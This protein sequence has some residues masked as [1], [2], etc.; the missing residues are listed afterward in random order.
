MSPL[1]SESEDG[2]QDLAGPAVKLY[3]E[4]EGIGA[5][6][7]SF[8]LD[9]RVTVELQKRLRGHVDGAVGVSVAYENR[10]G[11]GSIR[12][13]VEPQKIAAARGAQWSVAALTRLPGRCLTVTG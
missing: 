2:D 5:M 12:I 1:A 13:Q 10:T 11:R 8:F 3:V 4:F 9:D 7:K 6:H